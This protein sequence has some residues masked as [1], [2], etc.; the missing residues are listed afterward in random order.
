M[1]AAVANNE[2]L[3]RMLLER[4]ASLQLRSFVELTARDEARLAKADKVIALFN[5]EKDE[6]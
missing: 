4:G 5:L 6:L 2:E 3:C 1:L